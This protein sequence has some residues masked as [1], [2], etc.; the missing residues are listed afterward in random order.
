MSIMQGAFDHAHQRRFSRSSTAMSDIEVVSHPKTG[1]PVFRRGSVYNRPALKIV[2][3]SL[4]DALGDH[5]SR[6]A[7]SPIYERM[8]L[9]ITAHIHAPYEVLFYSREKIVKAA[10]TEFEP[11]KSHAQLLLNFM[12]KELTDTWNK[13]LEIDNRECKEI[14]FEKSWLLYRPEETVFQRGVGGWRAYKVARVDTGARPGVDPIRIYGYYLGFDKTGRFLAPQLEVLT[15][16]PYPSEQAVGSL[17][18]VPEWHVE[19]YVSGLS[20]YLE[21]R[22]S[23]YWKYR[24]KPFYQEYR[25]DAWPTTLSSVSTP[26]RGHDGAD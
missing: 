15:V 22:G 23:L 3:P 14:A 24:S 16:E 26:P 6:S 21:A 19:R 17:D 8:F 4:I 9:S 7:D 20:A 2:D 11:A 25:G 18:V 5:G 10:R 13:C 1:A 12:E